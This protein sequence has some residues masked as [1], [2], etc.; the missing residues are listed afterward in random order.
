MSDD[1]TYISVESAGK[2]LGVTPRTVRN[3]I[4]DGKLPAIDGKRGR[5]V[6]RDDVLF[7]GNISG[8]HAET[9]EAE[10]LS[11][12][13]SA[14]SSTEV[15]ENSASLVSA[16]SQLEAIREE[17]LQP[18]VDQIR[19]LER[20][21][22][23]LQAERD[24]AVQ[25]AE[26]FRKQAET[27]DITQKELERERD[28]LRRR[29]EDQLAEM[30]DDEGPISIAEAENVISLQQAKELE[31]E[32]DELRRR[33]EDAESRVSDLEQRRV[34]LLQQAQIAAQEQPQSPWWRR[35][36]RLDD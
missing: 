34:E 20:D 21:R 3:W 19:E 17:W 5:L 18:L 15:P 10:T 16:Y 11:G 36:L 33:A 4:N 2:L 8:H 27:G 25:D 23:R 35:L 7:L 1:S 26:T 24:R 30:D 31:A 6:R 14:R 32:R 29:L 22:G 9:A 13:P 12:N 28:E